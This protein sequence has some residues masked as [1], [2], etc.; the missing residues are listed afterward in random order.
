M[1]IQIL[2]VLVL[3]VSISAASVLV[4][5]ATRDKKPKETQKD[6]VISP[7]SMQ[8]SIKSR[9]VV[10][11][12]EIKQLDINPIEGD[13]LIFSSKSGPVDSKS[14]LDMISELREKSKSNSESEPPLMHSSKAFIGPIIEQ[15]DLEKILE[16]EKRDTNAEQKFPPLEVK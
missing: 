8:G 7:E 13:D 3:M 15:E 9:A 2:K 1:K 11:F 10:D 5:N 16:P 14:W 12:V 6:G 4:W